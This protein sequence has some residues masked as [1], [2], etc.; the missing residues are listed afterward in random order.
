M[1]L[2]GIEPATAGAVFA[3]VICV[4]VVYFGLACVCVRDCY[5]QCLLAWSLSLSL[6]LCIHTFVCMQM[7]T[8]TKY[9]SREYHVMAS[10]IK[11]I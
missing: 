2:A 5:E 8:N 6:S 3:G 9:P 10:P 1:A 11:N 4:Y 7:H